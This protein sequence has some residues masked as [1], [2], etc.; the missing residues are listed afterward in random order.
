M[1][2]GGY[3]DSLYGQTV[4]DGGVCVGFPIGREKLLTAAMAAGTRAA[5]A[6]PA[7]GRHPEAAARGLPPTMWKDCNAS[8]PAN[9]R[10]DVHSVPVPDTTSSA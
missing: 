7:M 10:E 4:S 3:V 8:V 6:P 2:L 1:L 9:G 5:A